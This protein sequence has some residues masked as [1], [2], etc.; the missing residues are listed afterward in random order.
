MQKL[1]EFSKK[2]CVIEILTIFFISVF[3]FFMFYGKQDAYLIDVGREAYIPW[4]MLK[5][6]LLYRDIFNVY[7]PL[8]YQINAL[9]YLVFGVHLN[10][11]YCAGFVNTL[12]ILYMVFFISKMFVKNY[13]ALTITGVVLFVCAFSQNFFSFI[14]TYSYNAIYAL[15]GFL[16]SLYF[17]L[18][19]IKNNK[20]L[21]FVL[22]FLFAGF[23]FAN[24]IE[25]LP[26]FCFLFACLP[27]W[28]KTDWAKYLYA[29]VSFFIFPILSFGAL[30]IQGVSFKD[31]CEAFILIKKLVSAPSTNYYY[32]NYGIYFD[33]ASIKYAFFSI[34][35]S[36]I[37]ILAFPTLIIFC[38]NYIKEKFVSNSF[39]KFF[40]NAFILGIILFTLIKNFDF[41]QA[42]YVGIYWWL[43]IACLLI[44]TI[45]VIKKLLMPICPIS[46]FFY[47]EVKNEQGKFSLN[48][49]MYLF[50][51]I[52]AI[53]VSFKG[54]FDMTLTCYGTFAITATIIPFVVF[55][56][57]YLPNKMS[58]NF[59]QSFIK[60]VVSLLVVS[61][62]SCFLYNIARINQKG[63]YTINTDKGLVTVRSVFPKQNELIEYIKAN[64]PPNAQI[65][66]TP[67]GALINFL[68]QRDSHNKYYYL[69]PGNVEVFGDENIANDFG[70]NPPDY[71][72]TNDLTYSIFNYGNLCT[73]APKV[74]EFIARNYT[75]ELEIQGPASFILYKRK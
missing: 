24:K 31:F 67:E 46:Q 39:L 57:N 41:V 1:I 56:V 51:L 5:G 52:S 20:V 4:Q 48:E 53:C 12:V 38:I 45:F 47:K 6:E 23:S 55:L 34:F 3:M 73:F 22:A 63:Q 60:T 9:L 50:L 33:I 49:K 64:T 29:I 28:F 15:S 69:I 37:K 26:Y 61:M 42:S 43:G 40:I 66:T 11:L 27:F 68:A 58:E 75:R 54:L 65:V 21:Y 62:L 7:G 25:N 59:K 70:K 18:K 8:G 44:L 2:Y 35:L 74:C 30:L 17:A 36:G 19:F 13:I 72:L 10:T 32:Q 14:F 16:L 71:F